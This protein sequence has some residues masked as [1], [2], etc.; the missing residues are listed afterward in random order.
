MALEYPTCTDKCA[1]CGHS[2]GNCFS[3]GECSDRE[4]RCLDDISEVGDKFYH[5]EC[6]PILT[7]AQADNLGFF[8]KSDGEE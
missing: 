8:H 4:G 6:T 3:E 1:D 7:M 2:L 5:G